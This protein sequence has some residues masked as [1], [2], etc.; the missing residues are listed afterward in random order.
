MQTDIG[1]YTVH[2]N[3]YYISNFALGF[4]YYNLLTHPEGIKEAS[5]FQLSFLFFNITITRWHKWI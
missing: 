1:R 5:V 4:D 3:R 2:I